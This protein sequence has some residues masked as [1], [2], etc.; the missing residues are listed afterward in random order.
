MKK[1]AI[2]ALLCLA[3]ATPG[4]AQSCDEFWY[5]RNMIYKEAG[6]CFRTAKAIRSFGN[7]GC[8]YDDQADV[9]LS[10]RLRAEIAEIASMERAM[11]CAP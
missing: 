6:Y 8:R 10:A 11:R 5:Q 3:G 1:T 4:L 9:P 7:A 2:A